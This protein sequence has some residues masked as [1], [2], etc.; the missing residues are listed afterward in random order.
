MTCHSRG[1][2]G[3]ELVAGKG[4]VLDEDVPCEPAGVAVA[5]N[6]VPAQG[7]ARFGQ[8]QSALQA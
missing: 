8:R 7:L 3:E 1:W 4:L 2:V 6:T 5:A